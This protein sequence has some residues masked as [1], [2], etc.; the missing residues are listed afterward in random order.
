MT[1]AALARRAAVPVHIQDG[2]GEWLYSDDF[3]ESPME[4]LHSQ[5]VDLSGELGVS[6]V[7]T[8]PLARASY[9]EIPP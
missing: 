1:A 7:Q 4:K 9:P 2:F 5:H 6:L 8:A 3:S